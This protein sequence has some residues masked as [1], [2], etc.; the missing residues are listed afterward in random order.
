[1]K[2]VV[3]QKQMGRGSGL[4]LNIT[5]S[6]SLREWPRVYLF[7]SVINI[8]LLPPSR[9]YYSSLCSSSPPSQVWGGAVQVFIG[10][11]IITLT[12]ICHF[13]G[14]SILTQPD[15][16]TSQKTLLEGRGRGGLLKRSNC[17]NSILFS[18]CQQRTPFNCFHLVMQPQAAG[19]TS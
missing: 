5:S 2:H 14:E 3:K 9:L 10:K 7:S 6:W 12:L 8:L 15:R 13:L 18:C 19:N 4:L 17:H 1:M 16:V 11:L